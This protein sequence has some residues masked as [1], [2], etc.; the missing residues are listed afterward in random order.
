MG[1]LVA[2]IVMTTYFTI[3]GLKATVAVNRVQ[4]TVKLVGF[5]IAAPLAVIGARGLQHVLAI[6][7]DHMH[8]WSGPGPT[9]AAGWQLF[10]LTAP[11]FVVSPAL[12]QKAFAA[13]DTRALTRGIGLNG[14][15]L[16]LFA[17]APVMLGMAARVLNPDLCVATA[18]S[19]KQAAEGALPL[20]LAGGVPF[21]VGG[22][23]L[24]AILS[25]EMSAADAVLFMLST[26]AARDFYRGYLRPQATDAQV[27]R[28]ARITAIASGVIGFG[29]TFFSASVIDGLS[30][31]YALL[32]VT[33]FAP[34]VGA[35]YLRRIN[36]H[37]ALASMITGIAALL[38]T[39]L[40]TPGGRGWGWM[41]P[42][43]VGLI[44]SAVVYLAVSALPARPQ[45]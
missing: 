30:K 37:A 31:F 1:C 39:T 41:G 15:F 27:L 6:N 33:L 10:F 4:L 5:A 34:V 20:I 44:A 13:R 45:R 16:M 7:A 17:A 21:A 19:C 8:F 28:T 14:L 12:I 3:G 23:A 11:A 42:N 18:L 26:S 43:V 35:L 29:L 2:A 22:L 38:I 9:P 40:I 25:A 32:G 24:A 36:R